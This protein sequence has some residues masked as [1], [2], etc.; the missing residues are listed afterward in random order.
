M[1]LSKPIRQDDGVTTNYHR[2]LFVQLTT[3]KQNS[4]A[5]LSYVDET[6]RDKE[7]QTGEFKPYCRSKTYETAYDAA[8][9]TES[10]YEFLKSH[11]D[12]EGAT[13]I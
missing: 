6:A 9:S 1:A 13:D 4:I 12:F 10:A 8:M 2:I 11:K 3:N 5:V 7:Q